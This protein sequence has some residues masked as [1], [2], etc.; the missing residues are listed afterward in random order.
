MHDRRELQLMLT[1][2]VEPVFTSGV[3]GAKCSYVAKVVTVET[4]N[5]LT[6]SWSCAS[7]AMLMPTAISLLTKSGL[8]TETYA[9]WL[10]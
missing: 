9:N 4:A 5:D 8:L 6:A 3:T 1:S 2:S 10:G 7:P